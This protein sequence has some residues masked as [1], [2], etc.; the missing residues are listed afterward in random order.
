MGGETADLGQF[1]FVVAITLNSLWPADCTGSLIERR[2][3]VT[4][5]HCVEDVDDFSETIVYPGAV[6]LLA[7]E[8]TEGYYVDKVYYHPGYNSNTYKHDIALLKLKEEVELSEFVSLI[9]I[10]EEDPDYGNT[11]LVMGFGD[12]GPN[13]SENNYD[14]RF[15][16]QEVIECEDEVSGFICSVGG[17]GEDTCP[18]DSG[19]PIISVVDDQFILHGVNSHGFGGETSCGDPGA[20]T[21]WTSIA[22]N[23]DYVQQIMEDGDYDP[24]SSSSLVS[25]L[26]AY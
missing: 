22:A 26:F 7:T 10:S 18:G 24:S 15:Q 14:L 20:G 23:M 16:E 25:F 5:A 21:A 1:P 13:P 8:P 17:S 11:V 4:A 6:D 2:W 19:G 3:V 9:E 12:T